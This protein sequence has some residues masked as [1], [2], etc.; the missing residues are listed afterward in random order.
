[1][2]RVDITEVNYRPEIAPYHL[3]A[4]LLGSTLMNYSGSAAA[5][6]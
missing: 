5:S 6:T 1:V 4:G 3:G 2:D